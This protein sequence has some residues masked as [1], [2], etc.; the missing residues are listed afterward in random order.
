MKNVFKKLTKVVA[1]MMVAIMALGA[2]PL[3]VQANQNVT[4]IIDGRT[5]TQNAD[6]GFAVIIDGRTFIPLRLV[7]ENMGVEVFWQRDGDGVITMVG[8]GRT[9]YHTVGQL[10][11]FNTSSPEFGVTQPVSSTDVASF[12]SDGRTMVGARL[13][14]DAF[15]AEVAWA[16][17]TRTVTITTA[18]GDTP[19]PTGNTEVTVAHRNAWRPTN[20]AFIEMALALEVLANTTVSGDNLGG[21]LYTFYN[22][23]A[24]AMHS[25][26]GDGVRVSSN[27]AHIARAMFNT[28]ALHTWAGTH[29]RTIGNLAPLAFSDV[30]G[31]EPFARDLV[32]LAYYNV[33]GNR[34]TSGRM[35][36]NPNN[37]ITKHEAVEML[38]IIGDMPDASPAI[39]RSRTEMLEGVVPAWALTPWLNTST[40]IIQRDM[41]E[42]QVRDVTGGNM[43]RIEA[44]VYIAEFLHRDGI[45]FS[46]SANEA[47]LTTTNTQ[48][49]RTQATNR[50][51]D[52]NLAAHRELSDVAVDNWMHAHAQRTGTEPLG[53]DYTWLILQM[54]DTGI[55]PGFADNTWRPHETV[56]RGEFIQMLMRAMEVEARNR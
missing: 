27:R 46:P 31:T 19:P 6:T 22:G 18:T 43:N 14:S 20:N 2:F 13:I 47:R 1:V 39:V 52:L 11:A 9:V 48:T 26:H 41:N 4:I 30:T 54:A 40:A 42:R 17:A 45:S 55:I 37:P 38:N 49:F 8:H 56:T 16:G 36:F 25:I 24:R 44:A 23:N 51:S 35:A 32:L 12:I 28:T 15:G 21:V 53:P 10:H 29:N 3:T 7:S 33:I 5:I 34:H 50:F